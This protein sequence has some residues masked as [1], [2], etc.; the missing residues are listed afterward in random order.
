MCA[1]IAEEFGDDAQAAV[2]AHQMT[3]ENFYIF[4]DEI[5]RGSYFFSQIYLEKW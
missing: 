4:M 2:S 1:F 3:S 5:L